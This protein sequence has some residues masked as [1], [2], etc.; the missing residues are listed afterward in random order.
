MKYVL[1]TEGTVHKRFI[2]YEDKKVLTVSIADAKLYQ[3]HDKAKEA[4][5]RMNVNHHNSMAL[6][7]KIVP[8]IPTW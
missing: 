8:V 3:T 5:N 6:K 2:K 4:Q 7:F 1:M